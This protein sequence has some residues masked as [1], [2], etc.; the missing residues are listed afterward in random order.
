[1]PEHERGA[2]AQ[3]VESPAQVFRGKGALEGLAR[4]G[5]GAPSS[6]LEDGAR[7]IGSGLDIEAETVGPE[8]VAVQ[9]LLLV[10]C[11][12]CST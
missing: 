12:C 7:A 9:T 3:P 5:I 2:C 1:V 6:Q 11:G 10:R 8:A 4:T